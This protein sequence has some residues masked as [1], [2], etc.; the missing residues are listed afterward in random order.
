MQKIPLRGA[1]TFIPV[2]RERN[3]E[4][5]TGRQKHQVLLHLFMH[6]LVDSLSA[7]TRGRTITL[8]HLDDALTNRATGPGPSSIYPLLKSPSESKIISSLF[9]L[10]LLTDPLIL[11][12]F[13]TGLSITAIFIPFPSRNKRQAFHHEQAR[14]LF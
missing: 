6:S 7:L 13:R 1:T 9:F 11:L 10:W 8:V 12:L 4:R 5:E 14:W 3:G 2:K